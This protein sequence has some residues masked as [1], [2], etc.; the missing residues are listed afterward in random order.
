M[1]QVRISL[2]LCSVPVYI[3]DLLSMLEQR[4]L[5]LYTVYTGWFT[6]ETTNK[7]DLCAVRAVGK[8]RVGV[9]GSAQFSSKLSS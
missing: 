4:L 9:A 8:R 1:P 7:A 3:V 5:A 2:A 6:S